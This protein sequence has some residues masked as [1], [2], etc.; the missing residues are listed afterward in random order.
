MSIIPNKYSG[1]AGKLNINTEQTTIP[2]FHIGKVISVFDEFDAGRIKVRIKG[3][4]DSIS[5][6]D[7]P[8]CIPNLPKFISLTPQI[9]ETVIVTTFDIEMGNISNIYNER[10]WMGPLISQ[11]QKLK[12]DPYNFSS[13]SLLKRGVKALE[14][15]PSTL[16]NAKGIYPEKEWISIQGRD[17][18][19][20]ILKPSEV[21][22]RAGKHK[23][24][25]NLVFNKKDIGF[26]QIKHGVTIKKAENIKSKDETGSVANIVASKINLLTHNGKPTF[27]LNNQDD[28]ISNAELEKILDNAHPLVF[29]DK[30]NEFL[31]LVKTFVA[32]HVHPYHGL[33]TDQSINVKK[34]LNFDLNSLISDNVKTN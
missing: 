12:Y 1:G 25:N 4:D 2:I 9:G 11:P 29:G 28:Q 8:Y 19:D 17:N 13:Q 22:I 30:L 7:L 23:T 3:V 32:T 18:A 31:E 24:T 15:A 34:L 10:L 27:V 26:I 16:P 21:L 20:I 6:K 33:P 14:E 5:D